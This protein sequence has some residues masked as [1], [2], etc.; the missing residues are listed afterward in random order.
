MPDIG[1][2]IPLLVGLIFLGAFIVKRE[3]GFLI[4]GSIISGVSLG[5]GLTTV[6]DDGLEGAVVLLS[7]AGGFIAIW[8]SAC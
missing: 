2:W 5:V 7:L 1:I 8:V 4:A 3:Y 6:V